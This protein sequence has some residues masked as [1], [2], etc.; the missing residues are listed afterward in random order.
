MPAFVLWHKTVIVPR[1]SVIL[2]GLKWSALSLPRPLTTK[3]GFPLGGLT[4]IIIATLVTLGIYNQQALLLLLKV[5]QVFN[6]VFD[7][8]VPSFPLVGMFFVIIFVALRRGEFVRLLVNKKR[9]GVVM[10]AGIAMAVLPLASVFLSGT[11][12]GQSYSFAAIAL[13]TCWVGVL[14][15]LRPSV[16]HFLWPY[17]VVF[18]LAVGSVGILTTTFGDPLAVVVAWISSA[19]TG[20]LRV[21][22]SWS[23]LYIAFTAAGGAPV[24]LQITQECSGVASIAIFLLLIGLI[25][26][27]NKPRFRV[28]GL[29]AAAG[30]ILFLFLNSLRVVVL[31]VAGIYY[32]ENLLWSLHGW[33]GYVFYIF[34]YSVLVLS[35]MRSRGLS[36]A[37]IP[38]ADSLAQC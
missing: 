28:S 5:G 31:I 25:H 17:L 11:Y 10:I 30:F 27:D 26:L 36:T 14:V 19:I 2:R 3:L 8:S 24:T 21:P 6:G 38:S 13:A 4:P 9:E 7:T 22:V 20:I 37:R 33:V 23:S 1:P 15:A 32:G 34:G 18:L 29:F 12:L 35:F 16:F